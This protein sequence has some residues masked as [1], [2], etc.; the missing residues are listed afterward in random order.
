MKPRSTLRLEQT[1]E[2]VEGGGGGSFSRAA[3][4]SVS[5]DPSGSSRGAAGGGAAAAAGAE[6]GVEPA[7]G[8]GG[9][10]RAGSGCGAGA[11]AADWLVELVVSSAYLHETERERLFSITERQITTLELSYNTMD[12]KSN[13]IR[14]I[15][16]EKYLTMVNIKVF[17]QLKL[18]PCEY[19]YYYNFNQRFNVYSWDINNYIYHQLHVS[20]KYTSIIIQLKC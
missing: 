19:D 6:P 8:S 12:K 3:A 10:E 7:A 17:Y 1:E 9:R 16:S 2:G 11:A 18:Y 14:G 13:K 15:K 4:L 20:Q 5:S